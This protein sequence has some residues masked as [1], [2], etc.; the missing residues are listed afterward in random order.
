MFVLA[1]AF[2][3]CARAERLRHALFEALRDPATW[4]PAAGAVAF[5]AS[6]ADDDV[7]AWAVKETP[8]F[9]SAEG[10]RTASSNLK[11]AVNLGMLATAA[12]RE[13]TLSLPAWGTQLAAALAA[14]NAAG[15]F[16]DISG[17]TRPDGSDDLSFPSGHST[18][19]FAY[20][21]IGYRNIDESRFSLPVRR[22][23]KIGLATLAAGSA[24][25][26]VEGGAHYP[27]DVLAGAALGN[28]LA[29]VINGTILPSDS[30]MRLGMSLDA[31]GA[32]VWL[33][34]QR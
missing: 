17:R 28:F 5:A 14:P 19:A 3:S 18:A 8:V 2:P 33:Q 10:A 25:G 7:A 15:P 13:D 26:R 27:S 6:G 34:W 22:S 11:T 1:M 16:K 4:I 21:G 31:G 32:Q 12:F 23:L 29:V 30:D 24:W 9:G 20:A